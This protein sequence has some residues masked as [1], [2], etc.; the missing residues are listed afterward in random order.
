[1]SN[2]NDPEMRKD[3]QIIKLLDEL[4]SL[5]GNGPTDSKEVFSTPASLNK[6]VAKASNLIGILQDVRGKIAPGRFGDVGI[7][8]G[9]S[10]G[11]AKFFAFSF[12][13]REKKN[14][15]ELA[16]SEF[17]GSGV[18]A[19]YYHGDSV[20]SYRSL[21]GTETPIYV[22][23]A[24]PADPYAETIEA[25]GPTLHRRLKEHAKNISK[26]SLPL[27]DFYYR[28]STIQRGMQ[29]AVEEF[30]I[31]LFRPIWNKEVKICFGLGKHG[32]SSKTRSN[33]R[34]PWDTMHPGR[35]WATDTHA[36]QMSPTTIEE[37]ILAHFVEHPVIASKDAL[38]NRLSLG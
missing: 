5:M 14:L 28:A 31:R 24:D 23:K 22:G 8:L 20:E 35:D 11:I 9:R 6:F 2:Q 36:D 27:S 4:L 3:N 16:N 38:I 18:Y 19:I 21:S 13:N 7:T 12:I 17:Y 15:A 10:D 30:M 26:T 32:D 34:S 37:K 29:S 1:M 33:K 25:Q